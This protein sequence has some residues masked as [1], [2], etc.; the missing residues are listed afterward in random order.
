MIK[1]NQVPLTQSMARKLHAL[2]RRPRQLDNP[3]DRLAELD[4]L[5][6]QRPDRELERVRNALKTA[7]SEAQDKVF[8]PRI[9]ELNGKIYDIANLPFT[10]LPVSYQKMNQKYARSILRRYQETEWA[11]KDATYMTD[12]FQSEIRNQFKAE[13]LDGLGRTAEELMTTELTTIRELAHESM[14]NWLGIKSLSHLEGGG[15]IPI[16]AIAISQIRDA[17][18]VSCDQELGAPFITSERPDGGEGCKDVYKIKS[19]VLRFLDL[20]A[21]RQMKLLAVRNGRVCDF[22]FQLHQTLF[23]QPRFTRLQCHTEGFEFTGRWH[24][25]RTLDHKVI[26]HRGGA[27][28]KNM[29]KQINM[30]GG[31]NWK[32]PVATPIEVA[33]N[34]EIPGFK[35]NTE[36]QTR[37]ITSLRLYLMDAQSCCTSKDPRFRKKCLAT[38]N[39]QT[40][41]ENEVQTT[42]PARTFSKNPPL[43]PRRPGPIVR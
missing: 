3:Q 27:A 2:W 5:L 31:G 24:D 40:T 23:E 15:G 32:P 8:E 37:T 14:A 39:G 18:P 34:G 42:T 11:T 30:I 20:S 4:R 35:N 28:G 6:A 10:M 16:L 36:I 25:G 9:K 26:Y 13:L 33:V 43:S 1:R 22:Y 19:N 17:T 7:I 12:F 29:I 21:D 38:Y 41:S